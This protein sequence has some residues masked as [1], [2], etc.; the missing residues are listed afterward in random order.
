MKDDLSPKEENDDDLAFDKDDYDL[1]LE[2]NPKSRMHRKE[3]VLNIFNSFY[4]E[5]G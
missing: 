4:Q 1:P 5:D 3:S 2:V